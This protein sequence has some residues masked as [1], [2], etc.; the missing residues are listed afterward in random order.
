MAFNLNLTGTGSSRILLP[1]KATL[2][3]EDKL[4]RAFKSEL[5][6]LEKSQ[7]VEIVEP[8]A[9][10]EEE[11]KAEE[12]KKLAE[13]KALIENSEAKEAKPKPKPK[14]EPKAK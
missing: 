9:Q 6:E 2:T 12:E 8:I 1:A 7:S 3:V 5:D 10:T 14:A 13:A 4:A 11:K